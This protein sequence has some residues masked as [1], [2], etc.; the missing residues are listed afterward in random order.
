MLSGIF[1]TKLKYAIVKPI[2]KKGSKENV[3]NYRPISL[4]T[5]FSKVFERI[6]YDRLLKHLKTNN[7]L[8]AEQF[9]FRVSSSTEKATYKLIDDVLNELNNKLTVGGIFCDLQKAFDCI[10][11]N[12]LLAKLEFYSITGVTYSLL[13]SYLQGRYQR[14]VINNYSTRRCDCNIRGR[15]FMGYNQ[16]VFVR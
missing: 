9:G 10:N 15:F 3:T 12:I 6:I 4:L 13:K 7:I 16:E 5:S 8:C 11:H 1:P 14:V 2:L